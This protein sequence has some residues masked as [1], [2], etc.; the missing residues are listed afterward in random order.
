MALVSKAELL[1]S[2]AK[3]GSFGESL[4]VETRSAQRAIIVSP[5][6]RAANAASGSDADFQHRQFR[7]YHLDKVIKASSSRRQG[8]VQRK[9]SSTIQLQACRR[10]G[11]DPVRVATSKPHPANNYTGTS[12]ILRRGTK[13]SVL[14]YLDIVRKT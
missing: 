14:L 8:L 7:N 4:P 11:L 1:L 3:V 10:C 2:I 12:G 13:R 9:Q 5:F 6:R